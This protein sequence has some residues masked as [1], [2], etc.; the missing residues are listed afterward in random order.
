MKNNEP[1]WG[2]VG[3]ISGD[4]LQLVLKDDVSYIPVVFDEYTPLELRRIFDSK[5]SDDLS[6]KPDMDKIIL[7]G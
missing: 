6:C 3:F 1:F 2:F 4:L 5:T 7:C